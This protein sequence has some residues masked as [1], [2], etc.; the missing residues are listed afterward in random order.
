MKKYSIELID[1][2]ISRNKDIE[3]LRSAII[4][5]IETVLL[6]VLNKGKL[7]ICGNGGSASDS[8]HIVGELLKEFYIKRPIGI[9]EREVLISAYGSEGEFLADRLQGAIPAISLSAHTA[10]LTAFGNDADSNIAF[11]QEVYGY[12]QHGD[13]FMCLSTSGNSKN[14][15]YAAKV[16]RIKGLK[17]VGFTG[18]TGGELKELCDYLINVPAIETYRVQEYHLMLYHLI[19]RIVEMEIFGEEE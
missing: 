14:V 10:F 11:A 18:A 9:D 4:G 5:T 7:L 12:G 13:V 17:V 1:E 2:L 8:D 6:S 15:I 19:C 16:A 3:Y